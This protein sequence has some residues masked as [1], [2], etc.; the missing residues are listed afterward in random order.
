MCDEM[1]CFSDAIDTFKLTVGH[2]AL[3]FIFT[4]DLFLKFQYPVDR[5]PVHLLLQI[6]SIIIRS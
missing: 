5:L 3:N 4:L 1:D 2:A 6:T